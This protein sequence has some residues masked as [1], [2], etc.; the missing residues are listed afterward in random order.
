M[1]RPGPH[2]RGTGAPGRGPLYSRVFLEE[3]VMGA[4][5]DGPDPTEDDP[6]DEVGRQRRKHW[7]A[8]LNCPV[9]GFPD[10]TLRQVVAEVEGAAAL[11]SEVFGVLAGRGHSPATIRTVQ[12]YLDL[13]RALESRHHC[14]PAEPGDPAPYARRARVLEEL[15]SRL[16]ND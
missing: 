5:V 4:G 8:S 11:E 9:A 15:Q 12:G 13:Q 2:V 16:L 7:D 3:I 10:V 14:S 1:V 6:A